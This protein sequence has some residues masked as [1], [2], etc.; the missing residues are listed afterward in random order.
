MS[1]TDNGAILFSQMLRG[2]S[3]TPCNTTSGYIAVGNG[4]T[5]FSAS[6]TDLV[7]ASKFRIKIDTITGAGNAVVYSGT[8]GPAD[9][10]FEWIETA[11]C[12]ASSGGTMVG[13]KVESPSLGTK[14]ATQSWTAQLTVTTSA[15]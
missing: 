11:L 1:L 8:A 5:A 4:N 2:A 3:V 15:T 9:A 7:G 13:R 6:Q 14:G 12:N 10:Q